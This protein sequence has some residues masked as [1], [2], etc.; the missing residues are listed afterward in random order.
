MS[1]SRRRARGE[2]V[3]HPAELAG[4]PA[5][6]DAGQAGVRGF[7]KQRIVIARV[8]DDEAVGRREEGL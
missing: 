4:V 7:G 5:D 2:V 8:N 3:V 1:Q 6:G